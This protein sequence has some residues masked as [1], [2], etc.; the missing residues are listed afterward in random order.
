MDRFH[1]KLDNDEIC[2][3]MIVQVKRIHVWC[4]VIAFLFVPINAK[5]F[6]QEYKYEIGSMAGTSFY[7]GD[8]NR[9]TVFLHP[10]AAGGALFRYNLNLQ[11]A[12]KT[13]IAGGLISGNTADSGN[14]FPGNQQGSFQRALVDIGS[15]VE[16]HFFRYSNEYGYLGTKAYT[17]YLF[18]GA[19]ITIATGE[20]PFYGINMPL[21]LGFKYKL[22]NRM[23]IGAEV[24]MRKLFRDDL[25]VAKH[26]QGWSLDAPFGIESSLLKN[27]DWYSFA[28]IYFTWDFGLREDPCR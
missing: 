28:V 23:N 6:S 27:Q 5:L 19:G 25:D 11:W 1:V 18:T 24:S 15:Q 10:G 14:R 7:L 13:N 9:T 22:K 20:N 21:G 3:M 26:T 12:I 8:A 4:T 2:S 17:P 16:F